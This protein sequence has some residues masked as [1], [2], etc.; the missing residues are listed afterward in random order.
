MTTKNQIFGKKSPSLT[1]KNTVETLGNLGSSVVKQ[2]ASEMGKI[3][4]GIFDQLFGNYEQN[5]GSD[6]TYSQEQR[7]APRKKIEGNLFNFSNYREKEV[8][9]REIQVLTEEIKKTLTVVKKEG[10]EVVK[11]AEKLTAEPL[12]EKP[13]IYHERFLQIILSLLRTL[14]QQIGESKTWLQAMVSKK[15]KRGS[16]FAAR[17][18]EK[19]TQYSLSQELTTA[20]AVQ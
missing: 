16:L 8:I 20:R 14:R 13:G 11:A 12:S 2:T 10:S 1:K 7:P 6:T 15:K 3:G 4:T 9:P 5:S 18:K 17:S 19:G